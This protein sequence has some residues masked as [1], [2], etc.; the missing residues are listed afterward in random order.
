M[1]GSSFL[2]ADPWALSNKSC[3]KLAEFVLGKPKLAL[4][5]LAGKRDDISTDQIKG[6]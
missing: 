2:S 3:S 5:V 4:I 6:A 1:G